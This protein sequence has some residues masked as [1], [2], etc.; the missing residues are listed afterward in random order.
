MLPTTAEEMARIAEEAQ[1]W[2]AARR[3]MADKVIDQYRKGLLTL[4][5]LIDELREIRRQG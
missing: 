3:P 2:E 4:D 5:E 1:E